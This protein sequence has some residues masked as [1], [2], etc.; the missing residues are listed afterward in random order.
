ML[1]LGGTLLIAMAVSWA[2][3]LQLLTQAIDQ[4]LDAQLHNATSILAEGAFPF[5]P[6][7]IG[8]LDRLI[9]ARIAL[10]DDAGAIGL[11][12]GDESANRALGSLAGDRPAAGDVNVRFV[13]IEADDLAWRAAVRPLPAARDDRYRYVVAAAPLAETRA[14]ATNAALLLGA[15]MFLAA[16]VLAWF[17]SFF[18]RSITRPLEDLARMAKGIAEGRRDVVTPVRQQDEIGVLAAALNDM[19]SRLD[20]YEAELAQRSRLAGL[21]DLAARMAHE[22]RNPLTAIKMQ[23]ELL[24]RRVDEDERARIKG[25][26]DEIRRLELI[27]HSTL[28]LGG[29]RAT[30]PTPTDA[31]ALVREVAELL[32]PSLAHRHIDLDCEIADLPKVPADPDQIKQVLLNLLN[33]A[34]EA[35]GSGGRIRIAADM[36]DGGNVD[37]SIED[38]GPGMAGAKPGPG[39]SKP[40]GLGLGLTISEEIAKRHGG[41]LRHARSDTLGGAKFTL[42]LPL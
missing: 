9:E 12:T 10:L 29:A 17:G 28:A 19:A 42:S 38:S 32:Q 30:N 26:L 36:V 6:D 31:G 8:R 2:I 34:A 20:T 21:G 41:S 27:V 7:L 22:L 1:P 33:N 25:L 15:A 23:L 4:R 16:L 14:V 24:E 11:S 5:S 35:L 13:T 40:L 18:T 39:S 37:I 3:A